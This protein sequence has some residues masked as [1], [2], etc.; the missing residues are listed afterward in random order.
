MKAFFSPAFIGNFVKTIALTATIAGWLCQQTA[1]AHAQPRRG[2][3]F[4]PPSAKVQY[5]PDRDYDLKH[6]K[7][8]LEVDYPKRKF[9]GT[10][11][12]IL[13]PLRNEGLTKIRLHCGRNLEVQEVT[14]NGQKADFTR[15]DEFFVITAPEKIAFGK[16]ASVLIRYVG[17]QFVP[18]GV[19][20]DGFHWI[21]PDS[22]DPYH[23]GFWTQGETNHNS[24]WAPT[25]DYPND[26]VTSETITT[27]PAEW[28]VI[29]NGVKVS[30]KE[31]KQAGTRTVHWKMNQPHATYLLALVAGPFDIKEA[32]WEG[33]PLLYVVPRGKGHLIDDSFGD[34]PDMLTF[35]S[36]ITGVKYP[37]EKY[38]Q[39]AMYEYGG[40]M[41]N[42][43]STTLG[44]GNL[45]DKRAG[46]REMSSLN[47]HE[48][49]HQWFG[50]LVT[51][52]NW[53]E[54]WLNESF[55]TFFDA[56]YQEYSRGPHAYA[57]EIE[58]NTRAYLAESRR[59]KR[60]LSTKLYPN[61]DA[62]FDSHA[63]PKGSVVLHTL[64][65]QLGDKAFFAGIKRYLE[66]NRYQPVETS[67]LIQAMTEASGVNVQ[68]FFDQWVYRPGHPVIAYSWN[69]DDAKGQIV[70]SVQQAQDTADGTPVYTIPTEVALIKEGNVVYEPITLDSAEQ[71]I[72]IKA[73]KPDALILAPEHEFLCE[74]PTLEWGRSELPAIIQYAPNGLD[75]TLALQQLLRSTP[76]DDEIKMVVE[77]LRR[78]TDRFPAIGTIAPLGQLKREELRPLFRDMLKHLSFDRQ[79]EAV[80]ALGML[81]K[82][83]E[84]EK[85]LRSLVNKTAPYAVVTSAIRVLSAWDAQGNMEVFKAAAEMDSL[86]EIIRTVA[87][88]AI[89]KADPKQ[90]VPL[91]L[92]AIGKEKSND[93][94]L[95]AIRAMRDM[96]TDDPQVRQ[97]LGEVLKEQEWV[98]VLAAAD[99]I[100]RRKF[101]EMKPNLEAVVSKPPTGAPSW[102]PGAI[103]N[104]IRQMGEE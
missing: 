22:K 6:L 92:G 38:A 14:V 76:T 64:R 3:P 79:A 48:L 45:T 16:E 27:V 13:T 11:V 66:V 89:A 98:L 82:T 40:G 95:A 8:T 78:D 104:I 86:N 7:V 56:L 73:V 15:D 54:I 55:A 5:A 18:G 33:K 35:F 26:F 49:A 37:W 70:L 60:P 84:D 74:M 32:K 68:P 36:R 29:G 103:N 21:N 25:W 20:G 19:F 30:D 53:G 100:G 67:N 46:F 80:I 24:E 62:L 50:D 31:N 75:R 71:K 94:R 1:P 69:Y 41:E 99:V 28:S 96:D 65:R 39:N 93:Q 57:R 44:V 102:F 63:Y 23:V 51:C 42:V 12:N 97:A 34:T 72:A 81:P 90:G 9:S 52:K 61:A 91:L 88:S 58:T 43:S 87:Y 101:T 77:V 59:Y 85:L 17:G 4:L 10:S 47:A 2:N 83:P